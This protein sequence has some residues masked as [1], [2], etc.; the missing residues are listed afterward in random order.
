MKKQTKHVKGNLKNDKITQTKNL[1]GMFNI[2]IYQNY[3]NKK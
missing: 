1:K 3:A 2:T